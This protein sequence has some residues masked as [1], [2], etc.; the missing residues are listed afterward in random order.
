MP[1]WHR[2]LT[3]MIMLTS[4]TKART[5]SDVGATARVYPAFLI[6]LDFAL[7]PAHS[8]TAGVELHRPRKKPKINLFVERAPAPPHGL[9]DLAWAKKLVEHSCTVPFRAGRFRRFTDGLIS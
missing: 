9:L 1:D 5:R 7:R 2:E 6:G 3:V 8:S 4:G